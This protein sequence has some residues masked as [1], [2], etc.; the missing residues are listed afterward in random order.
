MFAI[1]SFI[2]PL[3]EVTS[4]FKLKTCNFTPKSYT[5]HKT[6]RKFPL[7]VYMASL[8][9]IKDNLLTKK[10]GN[11][12]KLNY[13]SLGY[14][15]RFLLFIVPTSCTEN[16]PYFR[17]SIFEIRNSINMQP[18]F[19]HVRS[20]TEFSWNILSVLQQMCWIKY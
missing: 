1:Q 2:C 15:S 8:N 9:Q 12:L 20:D 10:L 6:L 16:C 11:F 5:V 4:Y 3:L 7:R 14:F 19:P 17:I 18:K 13:T